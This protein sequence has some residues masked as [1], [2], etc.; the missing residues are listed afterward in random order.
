MFGTSPERFVADGDAVFSPRVPWSR[1]LAQ[2]GERAPVDL[3]IY[4]AV[5]GGL[6]AWT[7]HGRSV[8]DFWAPEMARCGDEYWLVYTARQRSNALAIGLAR[9]PRPT[10]PWRDLGHPL[11]SAHAVNTTGLPEDPTQPAA[12]DLRPPVVRSTK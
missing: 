11:I 7:A 2:A 4:T 5:I 8:G 10:G 6:L 12:P 3:L 9:A 1:W